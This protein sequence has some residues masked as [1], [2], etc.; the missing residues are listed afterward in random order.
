MRVLLVHPKRDDPL[1]EDIKLPPLGI[2]YIAAVLR[3][4]G[5]SVRILDAN[6]ERNQD[7]ALLSRL[8]SFA[9]DVI[10]I[11]VVSQLRRT[12]LHLAALAKKWDKDIRVVVGGSHPTVYPAQVAAEP[13]VDF[14]VHGEGEDTIVELMEVLAGRRDPDTVL[15]LAFRKDGR[16][17]VNPP[18]PLIRPLDR[19]PFPAY[20]L[21]P[22]GRY[23]APQTS[24]PRFT[25]MI[26]SRG[27]RFRCI[28]CDAHV[29]MGREFRAH[30][31]ERTMAEIRYLVREFGIREIHFKDSEFSHDRERIK[32]LCDLLIREG[33][34]VRWVCNVRIGRVDQE[35]L[36]K[37]KR[38][39]CLL[40]GL[41]VESGD[42]AVLNTLRKGTTIDQ[43]REAFRAARAAGVKTQANFLFGNP[44]ED[45]RAVLRSIRLAREL[46]P[47]FSY[48]NYVVPYA[49]TDLHRMAAEN[50]WLREG[51]DAS[52]YLEYE[53]PM[54]AARVDPK[55]LAWLLRYAYRSLFFRPR[56]IATRL[57]TLSPTV[58]R[59]NVRGLARILRLG[60][61]R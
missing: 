31:P 58:W 11:S 2:A 48:F 51:F 16:I 37:M 61:R 50:G 45:V 20:D 56:F 13:D 33:A 10:G 24:H 38:A 8:K 59:Y 49:G 40:V 42:Q 17:A 18:R 53:L 32:A 57:F 46:K 12:A 55:D 43:I 22:I 44:G 1:F 29:V 25:G 14:A 19:L 21:L 28:F 54:R 52:D 41:G 35:L 26:T 60:R 30:S 34:P 7:L 9:P 36:K 5:H 47:D 39:G 6:L 23:S 27:C 15:G 3:E 4:S